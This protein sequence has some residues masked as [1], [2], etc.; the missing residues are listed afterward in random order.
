MLYLDYNA[1]HPPL[2]E[3]IL[4]CEQEYFSYYAN[5]SGLSSFSQKANSLVEKSRHCI[6]EI[7][8]VDED[9]IIFTS[10]ASEANFLAIQLITHYILNKNQQPVP[11]KEKQEFIKNQKVH[12]LLSPLEHPSVY[13]S[14]HA[15]GFVKITMIPLNEQKTIDLSFVKD[16]L[17]NEKVDMIITLLI[18]NET[19]IIQ[20]IAE[21]IKMVQKASIPLLCDAVQVLSRLEINDRSEDLSLDLFS[22]SQ[23]APVFFTFA[24][25]KIGA[26]FGAGV[27]IIPKQ[28]DYKL[29]SNYTLF[30]GG[31]Q[32]KNLRPG[33]H[34]LTSIM[35]FARVLSEQVKKKR[36]TK[37]FLN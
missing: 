10:S 37:P 33:S 15:L 20:P 12:V 28:P 34:N 31:S 35:A 19:G 5:S 13:E 14:I 9:Q 25:H 30:R 23:K 7:L 22:F 3:I 1:T 29:L 4:E 26:G 2:K 17:K 6:A 32:E 18:H 21:L 27:L 16:I 36:I 11:V 24:G 8:H